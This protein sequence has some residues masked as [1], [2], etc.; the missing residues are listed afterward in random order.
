MTEII[1]KIQDEKGLDM[2]F[3]TTQVVAFKPALEITTECIAAFERGVEVIILTRDS[4][5][6]DASIIVDVNGEAFDPNKHRIV[7]ASTCDAVAL[8]TVLSALAAYPIG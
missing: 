7:S 4:S 1:K 3:D 6:S 8:S 2:V 5:Y